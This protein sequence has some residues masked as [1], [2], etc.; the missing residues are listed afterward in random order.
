MINLRSIAKFSNTKQCLSAIAQ[1]QTTTNT[2]RNQQFLYFDSLTDACHI[3]KIH[4][5]LSKRK[6]CTAETNL[7]NK[8]TKQQLQQQNGILK[9]V[10]HKVGLAP[11]S[12]SRLKVA[13]HMLYETV[14]D[15]INYLVFFRDFKLPN[16]FNSWF[17]VTELHVWML[18]VRA[19]AE[20][21]ESGEDG[22]FLRNCIVE[23]MW[24]DVNMRAKKLGANNPSQTRKQI[25][26]LSEQFQA[27]LI[28]YDEGAMSNDS[29]MAGALWRRFFEMNCEDYERIERL[30]KYVR[31]QM[32]MLDQLSREEFIIKPKIPWVELNKITVK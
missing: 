23:A 28:A 1:L 25:E 27:A 12:K 4:P 30:V 20:G 24:G 32:I 21:S 14:A 22:R 7:I 9:R 6:Y 31:I 16:T 26:I 3:N 19:M 10:L 11:N 2:E 8:Q 17:L 5:Q 29:I 18:L 15:K 13:S